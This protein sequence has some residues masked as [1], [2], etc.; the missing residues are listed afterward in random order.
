VTQP[1]NAIDHTYNGAFTYNASLTVTDSRGKK[2][3]NAAIQNITVTPPAP[4]DLVVS[5]SH[6][7][8]FTQGQKGASLHDQRQE[9]RRGPTT[10]Q[11]VS[12]IDTLPAGLSAV[13]IAGNGWTCTLSPLTCTRS[14]PVGASFQY[15][16][17]YLTVN[18]DKK[19]PASVVNTVKVSGG[20]QSNT[21]NDTGT[22]PT[23]IKKAR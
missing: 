10:S 18:V 9:R 5:K 4:S 12:V 16:A 20:G 21:G 6:A 17:I 1:G 22:D 14:D 8:D 3:E 2:S 15:P 11:A 7:G 23:N 19:A 13:S